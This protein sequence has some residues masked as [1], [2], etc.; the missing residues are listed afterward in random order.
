M[1][2]IFLF[3]LWISKTKIEIWIDYCFFILMLQNKTKIQ[4]HI[5]FFIFF[6]EKQKSKHCKCSLIFLMGIYWGL[7]FMPL[8]NAAAKTG[9]SAWVWYAEI[10]LSSQVSCYKGLL[11][12]LSALRATVWLVCI[13]GHTMYVTVLGWRCEVFGLV[14]CSEFCWCCWAAAW[15]QPHVWCRLYV[16]LATSGGCAAAGV[17]QMV[18]YFSLFFQLISWYW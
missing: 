2:P 4:F 11:C 14:L 1:N 3:Q 13:E 16:K 18:C 15:W 6:V 8:P 12:G 10:I 7:R 9:L 17:L 5:L